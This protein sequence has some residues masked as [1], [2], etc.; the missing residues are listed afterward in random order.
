V[1]NATSTD[2]AIKFGTAK[3]VVISPKKAAVLHDPAAGQSTTLPVIIQ[4]K[5]GDQWKLVTTENWPH[6]VRFRT[7]LFLYTSS[8]DHHMAFHGISERLD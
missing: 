4:Q 7:F 5:D 3:P 6:D 8:R 2:V 1:I